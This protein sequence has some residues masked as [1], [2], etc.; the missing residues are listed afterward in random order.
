MPMHTSDTRLSHLDS[1]RRLGWLSFDVTHMGEPDGYLMSP[2]NAEGYRAVWGP[3]SKIEWS[4]AY[5][6]PGF[7]QGHTGAASTMLTPG[8]SGDG[9]LENVWN[10][11]D[12]YGGDQANFFM[13]EQAMGREGSW[14]LVAGARQ[15][16]DG[17]PVDAQAK[18]WMT[19][20]NDADTLEE[21]LVG[22]M[23][24]GYGAFGGQ[25]LNPSANQFRQYGS[26]GD[27]LGRARRWRHEE[28]WHTA[29]GSFP[30]LR[31]W[32]KDED[33]V[34]GSGAGIHEQGHLTDAGLGIEDP[35][36]GE[37]SGLPN[38]DA[39]FAADTI[40]WIKYGDRPFLG[41]NKCNDPL[42]ANQERDDHATH[43]SGS[44][45]RGVG[46]A[47]VNV[48][49]IISPQASARGGYIPNIIF[50]GGDVRG[51]TGV[52]ICDNDGDI[53]GIDITDPGAT[54][55]TDAQQDSI[56][57][58][59]VTVSMPGH[60]M[61]F[62]AKAK[63]STDP[64]EI[65]TLLPG[66]FKSKFDMLVECSGG[67]N[68][69]IAQTFMVSARNHPDG[70]FVP[71]IDICFSSR[72]RYGVN[73][74]V[75][76]EL[77]PTLNGFPSADKI[78]VSKS[79]YP[80]EVNVSPGVDYDEMPV[81]PWENPI[82]HELG[83]ARAFRADYPAFDTEYGYTRFE[84]SYPIH[85][86]AGQEYS[87]VVRSNNTDYKCWIS[88]TR[89]DQ[90]IKGQSLSEYDDA[91]YSKVTAV[92]KKQYGGSFFR[93]Q[94][95]RTW[96]PDQWQD[97]MFRVNKC[98]FGG[99][100]GSAETGSGTYRAGHYAKSD[101]LYD[102]MNLNFHSVL[103]P[104]SDTSIEGVLSTQKESDSD[105][106]LTEV[107]GSAGKLAGK[108]FNE[109]AT[110]SLPERMK[111][112]QA[113]HHNNSSIKLDLTFSTENPDVSPIVDTRN[114]SVLLHKNIIGD[115]GLTASDITI[116]TPG[117]NYVDGDDFKVS[118]GGST[119]DATFTIPTNGTDANGRILKIEMVST[120]K[121]F[122]K[123]TDPNDPIVITQTSTASGSGGTFYVL[124]EEGQSGG[125]GKARYVTKTINLAPGMSARAIKV[126]MTARQPY[127][128]DIHV[129]YKA[130]AEEDD[131]S[132]TQKRWKLMERTSPNED[133]FFEASSSFYL[134][135]G[136]H[137]Y[138]FDTEELV[139]YTR[140]DGR[141]FDSF[142]SFAVKIV[143]SAQ[144]T[145]KT[146]EIKDFRAIAVF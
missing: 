1:L 114:M 91:G 13:V 60:Y 82:H 96:T 63:I 31:R 72:P 84:F 83:N 102:K 2:C 54:V 105:G 112:L 100:R 5:V 17:P 20:Q 130:L 8:L 59:L 141:T 33:P 45:W 87:I 127:Q 27:Y 4:R 133:S 117:Q 129:Y 92:H 30:G 104:G 67:Y 86:E 143:M 48:N 43:G 78:I 73:D 132:I 61:G 28:H 64:H 39:G 57:A 107:A 25:G 32:V 46:L 89:G 38:L 139:E 71:S 115:G 12:P 7:Q 128:S 9:Q 58:P 49:D 10:W 122:H 116:N 37:S 55:I 34:A 29:G 144:N 3:R 90:I 121:G 16:G 126:F 65:K 11:T 23:G 138:E 14:V 106:T 95:G 22:Y 80:Y 142:K 131:E 111:V 79:L 15:D 98:N 145:A 66:L 76:L 18:W 74:L 101:F 44:N 85:L 68:D 42:G 40:W 41:I 137:E 120:G 69:P 110:Q 99:T 56:E 75:W 108:S 62:D 146:P 97:L 94:N 6:K 118:G 35:G 50:H 136:F 119:Q 26:R 47:D 123:S 134:S 52:A 113:K 70:A 93:S 109:G 51:A 135:G 19:T 36:L 103:M 24:G 124:S 125:N 88:D 21:E 53:T 140:I 81:P 77:R